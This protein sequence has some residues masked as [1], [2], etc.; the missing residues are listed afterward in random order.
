MKSTF[1]LALVILLLGATQGIFLALLLFNKPGNK[2]ANRLLALLLISY[3]AFLA[4][5]AIMQ[6]EFGWQFPHLLGLAAGVIY[7]ITPLHYFYARS[8]ILPDLSFQ[9]K[10]L[11]HFFLFIAFYL[12]FLFPFYLLNGPEKIAYLRN[13]ELHGPSSLLLLFNW[14]LIFQG[15][16]YLTS[17]LWLLKKHALKIKNNFSS[18]DKINL[19]WLRNITLMTLALWILEFLLKFLQLFNIASSVEISVPLSIAVLIYAMGYLGLRQ[20]EIFSG[21]AE[22]K[23]L[24]KYERSGLTKEKGQELQKK[25]VHLMETEKPYTDSNLKLTQLA[26]MLSTSPNYLSQVI[27]EELN[28]NFFD[29][30]NGYRIEEAKRLIADP[31]NQNDTI[32]AIAYDVGFNSKSVFN[33]SFKKHSQ[34]TPSQ[35]R[36]NISK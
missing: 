32:L 22:I 27:N 16:S 10:Q 6:T 36:N 1:N 19:N 33:T 8:L 21:F 13:D 30:V 7:L 26:R 9:K 34:M 23:E 11:L 2:S 5:A 3:S 29:F 14:L 15:I 31:A 12:A 17:T 28:Q 25:L 24:K 4:D 18:I 35:F 20:P